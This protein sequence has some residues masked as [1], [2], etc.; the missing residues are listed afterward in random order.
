MTKSAISE[1]ASPTRYLKM[2]GRSARAGPDNWTRGDPLNFFSFRFAD[3]VD[4]SD[5]SKLNWI[6]NG[7]GANFVAVPGGSPVLLE[8]TVA[9]TDYKITLDEVGKKQRSS[10][11]NGTN[12][13]LN[14]SYFLPPH[15]KKSSTDI[16]F[17]Q[18][19]LV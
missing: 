11:I 4:Y 1:P 2:A 12:F 7:Y 8:G 14:F 3:N 15:S 17:I 16:Y 9:H 10:S 5:I 19:V 6:S 13:G 18:M